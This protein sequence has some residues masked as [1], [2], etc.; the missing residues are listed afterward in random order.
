MSD[1]VEQEP[2]VGLQ[3]ST[4]SEFR[5][6]IWI[7]CIF[8]F[9]VLPFSPFDLFSKSWWTAQ[10]ARELATLLLPALFG[11]TIGAA[12]CHSVWRMDTRDEPLWKFFVGGASAVALLAAF[13]YV[14]ETGIWV[15]PMAAGDT[16]VSM[17]AFG[18][19]TVSLVTEKKRRV[20]VYLGLSRSIY[21]PA[22][23]SKDSKGV[24]IVVGIFCVLLAW[25][26]VLRFY[27]EPLDAGLDTFYA[28]KPHAL[29]DDKNAAIALMGLSAPIGADIIAHGRYLADAMANDS[30]KIGDQSRGKLELSGDTTKFD[31][32][33]WPKKPSNFGVCADDET[34]RKTLADNTELLA[35]YRFARTLPEYEQI[36]LGQ[37]GGLFIQL[38]K[39]VAAEVA[40]NLRE[41]RAEIAYQ[42]WRENHRFLMR[43]IGA[44]V[45]TVEK[46][47]WTVAESISLSV[48]EEMLFVAPQLRVTHADELQAQLGGSGADR[49]NPKGVLRAHYRLNEAILNQDVQSWVHPNYLRNR[50]YRAANA[51]IEM[52]RGM[53][54]GS[55]SKV[56]ADGLDSDRD[57]R[58]T[59]DYLLHWKNVEFSRYFLVTQTISE[60]M[61]ST[62][63]RKLGLMRL[64][65]LNVQLAKENPALIDIQAILNQSGSKLRNPFDNEPMRWSAQH[66]VIYFCRPNHPAQFEQVRLPG[67]NWIENGAKL[68]SAR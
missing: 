67:G 6:A 7:F 38:N 64:L 14:R 3:Q 25:D 8:G 49:W 52:L 33:I 35:R 18:M 60:S 48:A 16:F 34:L 30:R 20:R 50:Q 31:C 45:S 22:S 10:I 43:N 13:I 39:L 1:T 15:W 17:L 55:N 19:A 36:G 61:A 63:L 29:Q 54:T 27:D 53:E 32:W 59:P 51:A 42:K 37:N 68:C 28:S 44:E 41:S 57:S 66:G 47:I 65:V 40:L 9:L 5:R 12:L 58:W 23:Q 26:G 11:F 4:P 21:V 56:I 62:L 2:K 46:L 24:A